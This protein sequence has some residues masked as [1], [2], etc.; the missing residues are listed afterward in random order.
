MNRNDVLFFT[1]GTI[2]VALGQRLDRFAQMF[3]FL[4]AVAVDSTVFF[5]VDPKLPFSQR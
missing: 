2:V 1:G 3:A 4:R 5:T